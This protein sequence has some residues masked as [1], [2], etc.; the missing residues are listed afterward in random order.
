MR[1]QSLGYLRKSMRFGLLNG[2]KQ[3]HHLHNRSQ[4]LNFS[5]TNNFF[6]S[7][8][9]PVKVKVNLL[10]TSCCSSPIMQLQVYSL[11]H[12]L[13]QTC[14]AA[15]DNVLTTIFGN[16]SFQLRMHREEQMVLMMFI[17]VK[18]TRALKS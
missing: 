2:K 17:D 16:M 6:L 15:A 3:C 10:I 18:K 9:C 5:I 13:C 12:Y 7:H 4:K 8:H 1:L 14:W 11:R